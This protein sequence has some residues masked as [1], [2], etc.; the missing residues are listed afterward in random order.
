MKK[1]VL[2]ESGP[3]DVVKLTGAE[4]GL[5]VFF[6][7]VPGTTMMKVRTPEGQFAATAL[8]HIT[9]PG[10]AILV[11]ETPED[12]LKMCGKDYRRLTSAVAL[13]QKQFS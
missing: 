11:S 10:K 7:W 2:E 1:K 8:G 6:E 13:P 12:I 5:E 3:A 9:A 4:N